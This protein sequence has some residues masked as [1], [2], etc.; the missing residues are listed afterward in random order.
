MGT[1][2]SEGKS[3]ASSPCSPGRHCLEPPP[4]LPAFP[5]SRAVLAP[6]KSLQHSQPIL[7]I[8]ACLSL[9]LAEAW[10]QAWILVIAVPRTQ[11]AEGGGREINIRVQHPGKHSRA[12]TINTSTPKCK[13]TRRDSSLRLTAEQAQ[14]GRHQN[15]VSA[16]T[17]SS[18][19]LLVLCRVQKVWAWG[20]SCLAV[21]TVTPLISPNCF[22]CQVKRELGMKVSARTEW[23]DLVSYRQWG[24]VAFG[25]WS[26][27]MLTLP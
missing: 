15:E 27:I 1:S 20:W 10:A 14:T 2:C 18:S 12:H 8:S 17:S 24:C 26:K 16:V 6:S 25:A 19:G 4:P 5:L 21:T 11:Q 9:P 7:S 3:I 23:P 13:Y 22:H